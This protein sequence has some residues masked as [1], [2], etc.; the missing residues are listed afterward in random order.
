MMVD[1]AV[2]STSGGSSC[3]RKCGECITRTET[4]QKETKAAA[5]AD[6]TAGGAQVVAAAVEDIEMLCEVCIEEP[7]TYSCSDQSL[8]T[9]YLSLVY[10]A[11]SLKRINI[12]FFLSVMHR[13]TFLQ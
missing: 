9:R 7:A 2:S 3:A 11:L 1:V 8:C 12:H 13:D 4:N 10:G 5:A 6:D